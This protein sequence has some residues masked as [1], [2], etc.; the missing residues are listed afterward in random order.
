MSI[1]LTILRLFER[2]RAK[3][4]RLPGAALSGDD[5]REVQ[6]NVG[7][8]LQE[9]E[10]LRRDTVRRID[11]RLLWM[12]PAGVVAGLAVA[13]LMQES[14]PTAL[15]YSLIG[16][17][18][19]ASTAFVPPNNA[20]RRAYKSR[21]IPHLAGRFGDLSYRPAQEPDLKRLATLGILP[22]FGKKCVEDEILGAYRDVRL[23]IVE[24]KLETGGKNSSVVFNGLLVEI[25]LSE[26][27][28]G[29]TVV[30]RDNS[31]F[32][33]ALGAVFRG[34]TLNRVRLEDP[35]FEES[36]QVY[37]SDQIAARALLTPAV[38]ERFMA[39]GK[40]GEPPRLLAEDRTLLV[41]IPRG[42][43][44]DYFEPPSIANQVRGGHQLRQL[45]ADIGSV[46]KLIDAVLEIS[47]R[48]WPNEIAPG[49][50]SASA[51][52]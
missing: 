21:V 46:L 9:L 18:L 49:E 12:A 16:L 43:Q 5:W 44:E 35:R 52:D 30:V 41:A 11:R 1:T 31:K 40:E 13:A 23:S 24:A 34:G 29:T 48:T 45:S 26:S 15:H 39:L 47:P 37:G 7:P 17:I 38:M 2:F 10:T 32:G 8:I 36:Y 6:T 50:R 28:H 27:L 4:A 3:P 22:S 42:A 19:G 33:I 51:G 20:Y 25:R 14:W